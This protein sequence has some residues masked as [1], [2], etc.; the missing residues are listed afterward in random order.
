MPETIEQRILKAR[1]K[2]AVSQRKNTKATPE[3]K[4]QAKQEL[5]AANC[6]AAVQRTLD[7]APPLSDVQAQRIVALLLTGGGAA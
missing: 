4:R 6:E 3:Q 1:S 7:G 2:V 5:A